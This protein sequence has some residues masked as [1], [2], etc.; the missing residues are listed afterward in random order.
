M[1]EHIQCKEVIYKK[2]KCVTHRE[3]LQ[4]REILS[5]TIGDITEK[6]YSM[7]SNLIRRILYLS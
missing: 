6:G 1:L 4:L 3:D 2:L 7:E 5:N